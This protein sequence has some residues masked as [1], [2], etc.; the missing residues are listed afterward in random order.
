MGDD[1]RVLEFLGDSLKVLRSLPEAVRREFGYNLSRVQSGETPG[2]AKPLKGF[3]VAVMEITVRYDKDTYRT[4]YTAK[5]Q[6]RVYVLHVFQK[7][8]KHGIKTAPRDL[9]CVRLRL[10]EAQAR[11]DAYGNEQKDY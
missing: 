3:N 8:S 2:D 11:E 4:M 9:E 1:E 7:K 5:L 6:R 10:I